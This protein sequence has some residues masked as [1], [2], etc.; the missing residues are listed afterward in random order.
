VNGTDGGTTRD[1]F[2]RLAESFLERFRRGE[3][4][5]ISEYIENNPDHASDIR[6]LFPAL[7]EVEQ[8]KSSG[9]KDSTGHGGK[10]LPVSKLGD[11]QIFGIVGEGGMGIV[12]EAIRESL[13][14]RVALKIMHPRFRDNPGYLRRFHVEAC[15]AASLHHTNIVSVFD[16]GET[17]GVVYYAMPYIAGQGLEKVL[18]DVR[19]IRNEQSRDLGQSARP[20]EAPQIGGDAKLSDI[21]VTPGLGQRNLTRNLITHGLLTG[22]FTRVIDESVGPAGIAPGEPALLPRQTWAPLE[23]SHATPSSTL[24]D[25]TEVRYYHEVARLGAQVA[26]ALAHAH[27]RGILHRDI[28]P[29]NL[30]LDA[31]G[32][33]WV[34]DFGL[35]KFEEG[36]DL[37]R[38]R[39]LIG[40]L[41]YMAP[42]RLRGVSNRGCDIYAL[43][44]TLYEMLTLLPPFDAGYQGVL[45]HQIAHDPPVPPTRHDKRI[46]RD[47]EIIVLKALAKDPRDRFATAEEMAQELRRFLEGRPIRSRALPGY[48]RLWRWCRR[49]PGLASLNALAAGLTLILALAATFAAYTFRSQRNALETEKQQTRRNLDRAESAEKDLR[50]QLALTQD[51]ERKAYSEQGRANIALGNSLLNEAA[52][53]QRG[54]TIGQRFKSLDRLREAAQILRDDPDGRN[55]IPEIRDHVIAAMGLT[56]LRIT[57][58][59]PQQPNTLPACDGQFE[60]Y[61]YVDLQKRETVVCR[62]A[63]GVELMRLPSPNLSGWYANV[64]FSP[65]GNLLRVRHAVQEELGVTEI[66]DL[67]H[68]E[69]VFR[70]ETRTQ[71]FLF[72]P[73]GRHVFYAPV[74]TG[75]AVWDLK[76]RRLLRRLPLDIPLAGMLA[77]DVERGRLVCGNSD[78]KDVRLLDVETGRELGRFT[79]SV[80]RNSVCLSGDARLLATGDWNGSVFVWDM[81]K[82][83]I[84]SSLVGHTQYVGGCLFAPRSH[85]LATSSWDDTLRLWDASL[86]RPLFTMKQAQVFNFSPDGNRLAVRLGE[87]ELAIAEV[88]HPDSYQVLNPE[89]IGN[90]TH[91]DTL[92]DVI[93]SATFSPDGQLLAIALQEGIHLYHASLGTYLGHLQTGSCEEILFD[94]AGENLISGGISGYYRWPIQRLSAASNEAAASRQIIQIGPPELVT[95]ITLGRH[96]SKATWLPDG[97]TLAIIDNATAQV[98]LVDTSQLRPAAKSFDSLHSAN[99]NRMTTIAI[100]PDGKW[101][102]CGGW[103]ELG[104]SIWDL[105]ARRLVRL[106][107]PGDKPGTCSFFVRFTPDGKRLISS[108]LSSTFDYFSWDV[109]TWERKPLLAEHGFAAERAPVFSPDGKL[110]SFS[111]SQEQIRLVD[112]LTGRTLANLSNQLSLS[113]TPIAFS[114]DGTRLIA[115]TRSKIALLWD[116]KRVRQQLRSMNV[117]WDAPPFPDVPRTLAPPMELQVLGRVIEASEKRQ[118]DLAEADAR[119]EVNPDDVDALMLRGAVLVAQDRD[120]DAIQVLLRRRSLTRGED[121]PDQL[122]AYVLNRR[123]RTLLFAGPRSSSTAE[124]IDLARKAVELSRHARDYVNTLGIALCLAGRDSEALPHLEDSLERGF[125]QTDA[126]DLYFLAI[127]HHRLGHVEE[128]QSLL[129]RAISW[130]SRRGF[131]RKALADELDRFRSEALAILA[132][133]PSKPIEK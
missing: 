2:D 61:A 77:L 37:S 6:E 52:A 3:R 123:A 106:L 66:W 125:G 46:P 33:I 86:G 82:Q 41:R 59:R 69:R 20:P 97:K 105:P 75:L 79:G 93:R 116:L 15:A 63:D 42:E 117:D 8:L 25:K 111:A 57:S 28:K 109:G 130:H 78:Q 85:L 88:A 10:R 101:A 7:V 36:D 56:D 124:P 53:L 90:R 98:R 126:Q 17:D 68:R 99:N 26:D 1:P 51:A 102:A 121:G 72:H 95:P 114:P 40:T 27:Q 103:K 50:I 18:L 21:T 122:L 128:A 60:R 9:A 31:L 44:A 16:Y 133:P 131:A 129:S 84:A 11:Y 39:D 107:Q 29:S 14:S 64:T 32:N 113:S 83:A 22:R 80:G 47:L 35:A 38:S 55:R 12:Y 110:M 4:P 94:H 108:S 118:A 73:N 87:S 23:P 48:E 91:E 62:L 89:M 74:G 5:S 58:T 120:D 65:D 92:G 30:L 115:G 127:A 54:G 34:T 19:R 76:L 70:E 96:M 104:I 112:S 45:M 71:T 43:G 67:A 132:L 24:A 49:N 81:S 119:L 13:R 100:S